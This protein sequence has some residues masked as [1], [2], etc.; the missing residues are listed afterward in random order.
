MVH[1]DLEGSDQLI[2]TILFPVLIK[3]EKQQTRFC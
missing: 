3:S 2:F 1:W